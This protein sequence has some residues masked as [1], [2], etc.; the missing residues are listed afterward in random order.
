MGDV[1]TVTL[2]SGTRVSCGKELADRLGG[3]AEKSSAKASVKK[4]EKK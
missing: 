1:V 3:T 4:T 2:P